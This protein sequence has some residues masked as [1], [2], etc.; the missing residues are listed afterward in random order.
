MDR[1]AARAGRAAAARHAQVT[2]A[3][4]EAMGGSVREVRIS[5]L[6]ETIFYA[7]V[8][9]TDDT[10]VDARPSDAIP[11]ALLT[12]APL[13]VEP[14]VLGNASAPDEWVAEADPSTEDRRMLADEVRE[15]LS[16]P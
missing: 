8:V 13:L 2:L 15:R 11:L 4:L 7:E 3:L 6:A 1:G 10:A 12:G 5:R 16:P 14:D 9:L